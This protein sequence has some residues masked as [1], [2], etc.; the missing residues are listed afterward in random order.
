ML[1]NRRLDPTEALM[2]WETYLTCPEYSRDKKRKNGREGLKGL[3][4]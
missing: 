3:K 2:N 1:L 4:H